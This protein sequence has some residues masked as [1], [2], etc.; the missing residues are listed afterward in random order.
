MT[1]QDTTQ[2]C[3]ADAHQGRRSLAGLRHGEV[4]RLADRALLL[5]GPGEVD[6]GVR[7]EGPRGV[8]RIHG[9]RSRNSQEIPRP[10]LSDSP[11]LFRAINII[12]G[13]KLIY[14]FV[15]RLYEWR[16]RTKIRTQSHNLNGPGVSNF[17]DWKYLLIQ[18]Q[19]LS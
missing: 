1:S 12:I 17:W 5:L 18:D 15:P 6:G 16:T 9:S 8:E 2:T 10:F 4:Q 19:L 7:D 11:L 13:C 14:M 3:C